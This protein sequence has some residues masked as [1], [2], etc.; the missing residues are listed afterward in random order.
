MLIRVIV[1]VF[2]VHN[3]DILLWWDDWQKQGNGASIEKVVYI[4]QYILGVCGSGR[5]ICHAKGWDHE[6]KQPFDNR[7]VEVK[8]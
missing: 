2:H 7:G 8:R 6:S 4:S 3:D 5:E 1:N